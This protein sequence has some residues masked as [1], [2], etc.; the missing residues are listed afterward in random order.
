MSSDKFLA[1][2]VAGGLLGAIAGI[3]LAPSSGK[4]TRDMIVEKS[5]MTKTKLE[6][7]LNDINSK[8][9]IMMDD[10]QKKGDELLN[11]VQNVVNCSK[12]EI[13]EIKEKEI[14]TF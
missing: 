11:K 6:D 12:K 5:Q 13:N 8:A 1:G 3:L 9:N 2:F 7:S 10:I 4:E 14:S